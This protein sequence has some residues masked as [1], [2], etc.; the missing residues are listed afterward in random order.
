MQSTKDRPDS[1]AR[2]D[3]NTGR[4]D[5]LGRHPKTKVGYDISVRS[6]DQLRHLARAARTCSAQ[7]EVLIEE[8]IARQGEG[9]EPA[10][11]HSW[12]EPA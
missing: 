3:P 10:N 7:P 5:R 8:E 1:N 2:A 6:R 4:V 9:L 11:R 12:V